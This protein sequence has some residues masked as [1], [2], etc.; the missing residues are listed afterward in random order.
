MK[1]FTDSDSLEFLDIR[2]NQ[3]SVA[4]TTLIL[5]SLAQLQSLRYLGLH[6]PDERQVNLGKTL[7]DVINKCRH[8]PLYISWYEYLWDES[9]DDDSSDNDSLDD[10]SSEDT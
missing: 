2:Y 10:D 7:H 8:S 6:F 5:D 9:S 3:F 4:T 1:A